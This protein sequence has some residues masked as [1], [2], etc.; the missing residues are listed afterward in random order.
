[1]VFH[2]IPCLIVSTFRLFSHHI[3]AQEIT[4][5][6][7]N[8]I[9]VVNH[10]K[11]QIKRFCRIFS[12]LLPCQIAR[13]SH[14]MKYDITAFKTAFRMSYRIKIGRILA[15]SNQYSRL[16][17]AQIFRIFAKIGVRGSLNTNS[18]MQEIKIIEIH[19]NDFVLGIVSLQLDCYHPFNGFLQQ[20]FHHAMCR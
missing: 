14:L 13:L 15:Q 10:M 16:R 19:S 12:I 11:F 7:S 3:T 6:Y 8:T 17:N 1:M 2:H 9:L 18:I 4:E 20:S 5:I